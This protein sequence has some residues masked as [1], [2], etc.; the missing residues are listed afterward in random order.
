MATLDVKELKGLNNR[1]FYPAHY[2]TE[3]LAADARAHGINGQIIK[4]LRKTLAEPTQ[5]LADRD[6]SVG[7]EVCDQ[8]ITQWFKALG[9]YDRDGTSEKPFDF[10]HEQKECRLEVERRFTLKGEGELWLLK[11][12]SQPRGSRQSDDQDSVEGR[13]SSAEYFH[14][15]S[16]TVQHKDKA[17]GIKWKQLIDAIFDS[18]HSAC[19]WLI[20]HFGNRMVLT[21]RGRWQ[22]DACAYLELDAHELFTTNSDVSYQV[23]EAHF[24][25]QSF[26]IDS[27][28]FFLESLTKN[29]HK[30]AAEVTKALRDTVRESIEILANAVLDAHNTRPISCLA[31]YNFKDR[32][33]RQEAAQAIFEQSLRFIYRM[34]FMLFTE[35]QDQRKG[36]LPVHSRAY[37]MGYAIEK[38]RELESMTFLEKGNSFIHDTLNKAFG[39]YFK[40]YN[41][42]RKIEFDHHTET[43]QTRTDALGFSFPQLGTDLFSPE[44]TL[45]FEE[46]KVPDGTMQKVLRKLS[47]ARFGSGRAVRTYRVHYAGLGLNQLG[48]VYEG[49]LSLKPEI[50]TEKVYLLSKEKKDIAYRFVPVSKAKTIDKT[51]LEMDEDTEKP[52]TREAGSFLLSPVGLER[53]FSASFYTPE[54]LTRF[55]AKESVE[56]L[57]KED[58]SLKRMEELKICEPAM[59]SGAFLN[60]VVDDLAPRMAKEYRKEAILANERARKEGQ[61]SGRPLDTTKLPEVFELH[62][63]IAKAKEHLM[64]HCVYGVDLNGTAVELAKISLWLN[65]IHEQG[66]LPFLDFKLKH[67]NSLVGCWVTRHETELAGIKLC[68]FLVPNPKALNIHLEARVLGER[69]VPFL[70]ESAK[71]ALKLIQQDWTEGLKDTKVQSRLAK[72][73]TSVMAL[74]QEH[75]AAR[76]EYQLQLEGDS[77]AEEKQKLYQTF[78]VKN[79]AYNQLRMLL[80]MW[81][82][83]WF[84]PHDRLQDLP[85]ILDLLLMMEWC[86][87][88]KLGYGKKSKEESF[89]KAGLPILKLIHEIALDHKFFHWDLEYAE[90]FAAG[91]FDLVLGNP[92]WAPI[93]WED[94]DFFEE[95]RPGMHTNTADSRTKITWYKAELSADPSILVQYKNS[96]IKADGFSKWLKCSGT[97]P[98]EDQSKSNTYR[99]FFQRFRSVSRIGSIYSII[100]QDGIFTDQGCLDMRRS[101][102]L[103]AI[104]INRFINE[105]NLFEDIHNLVEYMVSFYQNGKDNIGF[106]LIDN[107]YHPDTIQLCR[108]ESPNTEYR[109]MKDE[110][111]NFETRG[112]PMR[113]VN[114]DSKSLAS[115]S[116]SGDSSD[117]EQN[118]L[119]V[120]HGQIEFKVLTILAKHEKKIRN[121]KC[122][123]WYRFYESDASREG[124]IKR[125]PGSTRTIAHACLTGP[126]IFVGNPAYKAPNIPCKNNRDFYDIDLTRTPENFFPDTVFQTTEKGLKSSEYRTQTPWGTFH[127]E[128]FRII[129]RQMVSITGARTLSSA[130]IPPGPSHVHSMIS[131]SFENQKDLIA[132][133]GLFHSLIF[134][135]RMRCISG[136]TIG[137]GA[138]E[139]TPCLTEQQLRHPLSPALM[140][141]ALRLSCISSHYR[142]LWNKAFSDDYKSIECES[143]FEPKLAYGKLTSNW[144]Y[145]SCIRDPKQR[146]QAL[147]EID[148]IVAILFG[149]NKD[150]LLKLYRSQFGVL[151]KNLQDLPKQEIKA[152]KYHFPRYQ[153][154]SEAYDHFMQIVGKKTGGPE[155]A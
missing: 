86:V 6:P 88:T 43:Y 119:P 93:R 97:F 70:D 74:Y 78:L 116:N 96:F 52:V 14:Q 1:D 11:A 136:G 49:L 4:E 65:C 98:F 128:E 81:C 152:D 113:I 30:K 121:L 45:I 106:E 67:G 51:L 23:A 66:N 141:R 89:V 58:S 28:E 142:D 69:A 33:Q 54:V 36:A 99:Y 153:Q 79:T 138:F 17:I 146:E 90:V 95:V 80:D 107:L 63:Y 148:A 100:A 83:L 27:A 117:S 18:D 25:V 13:N 105:L 129:A 92:P 60:A 7:E 50:L 10:V 114:I 55:L 59:G 123:Y 151:Q 73:H 126:N 72:I 154:I 144:K 108:Q 12:C 44:K 3:S 84:W 122:L 103:E 15:I 41:R 48:A 16:T 35:S 82:S 53:K 115:L 62:H 109:G 24:R 112:H 57:L 64:R 131:I 102:F 22:E 135:F 40:G 39:I 91:G 8:V 134:D 61:R 37:Q 42:D 145:D 120:I 77:N 2:F 68:H 101:A 75:R 133:S 87:E 139:I 47:L 127:C 29:A 71:E 125:R 56:L 34:L 132:T 31:I 9:F 32:A 85:R 111:G 104:R 155:A 20:I 94:E 149:F 143:P 5:M 124:L 150:T 76:D 147:C 110:N 130:L 137:Q 118:K 38:L 21:E 26:P 19:E 140:I 46:I